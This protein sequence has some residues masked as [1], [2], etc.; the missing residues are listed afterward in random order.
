[1][2]FRNIV[3]IAAATL[4]ASAAV[5]GEEM[6]TKMKIAVVDGSDDGE[7]RIE[8]DSDELGFNLHDM[9]VGENQSIVDS[10]G[11]S[12]L[13]TR[14]ADGFA[15]N[16]DGETIKLPEL[17]A[18]NDAVWV[19]RAHDDSDVDVHVVHDESATHDGHKVKVIRKTV[20]IRTDSPEQ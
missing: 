20:E 10:S 8:L 7:V 5:A 9:Q 1:M 2:K 6:H 13:V 4:L 15:F 11:R 17:D 16:V 19:E 18:E 12:V 14:E 3:S